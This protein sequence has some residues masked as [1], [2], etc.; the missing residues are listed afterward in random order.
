MSASRA[1]RSRSARSRSDSFPTS[2][3]AA[4]SVDSFAPGNAAR[5]ARARSL[6]VAALISSSAKGMPRPNHEGPTIPATAATGQQSN[7]RQR[8]AK[9]Q[10]PAASEATAA[11]GQRSN[12]RQ[13]PAKQQPPAAS[14]ATTAS[15]QR[16]KNPQRPAEETH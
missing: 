13:R 14:E 8:P 2:P 7:S 9:Q 15:G 5:T 1:A 4:P 12:S 11:S 16:R 3:A 10:P 6:A